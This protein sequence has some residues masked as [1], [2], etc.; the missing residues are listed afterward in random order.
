MIDEMGLDILTRATPTLAATLGQRFDL[1]DE[2]DLLIRNERK[3]LKNKRGFYL[4]DRYNER[5]Q[6]D[7]SIYHVM[8]TIARNDLE[9]E[10]I[11]RRCLLR[12]LNEAAWCLQDNVIQSKEEGNVASVLGIGFPE[13]L[14]GIYAYMDHIGAKEI[15]HQ[16]KLHSQQYGARFAPCDWL[17]E[18]AKS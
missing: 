10:E 16:L 11:V 9:A 18:Q 1:P 4:Y 13:F 3:G 5:V 2:V 15:V 12:M 8:E 7:K 6:E 17:I 14:G